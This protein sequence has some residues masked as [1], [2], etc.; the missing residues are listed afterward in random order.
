MSFYDR[1]IAPRL[2][3]WSCGGNAVTPNRR[4][5]VPEAEGRVL[6]IGAGSGL[7]LP[8]Y[9][10]ARVSHLWA[11][12]PDA[13]MRRLAQPR[14]ADAPVG[15]DWLAA[16]AE[17]IPLEN[18]SVDTVLTTYTLCTVPHEQ[19]ALAEIRRVLKPGGRLLFCEH[20][21]A[22]NGRVRRW[23]DRLNGLNRCLGAGCNINRR[24]DRAIKIAGFTLETLETGY[25]A[26]VPKIGAFTFLGAG[27][28]T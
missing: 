27:R 4:R 15:P 9:D 8:F 13:A 24:P 26:G 20:G 12:E 17:A 21:A 2:I 18:A 7:N 28:P 6:E 25:L 14:I 1:H 5:I 3:D 16:S 10:P 19:R 22:P 23:Q 11:L